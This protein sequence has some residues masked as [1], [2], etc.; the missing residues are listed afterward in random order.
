[1]RGA[2]TFGITLRGNSQEPRTFESEGECIAFVETL[3]AE[4]RYPA[5]CTMLEV[6]TEFYGKAGQEC[7]ALYWYILENKVYVSHVTEQEF[8]QD[9]KGIREIITANQ[10]TRRRQPEITAYIKKH[11]TDSEAQAWMESPMITHTLL[12]TVKKASRTMGFQ[13]AIRK[14]NR[15]LQNPRRGISSKP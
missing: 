1:M 15:V 10:K 14:V 3:P 11:W 2:P 7:E 12:I 13:E 8:R 6:G 9:W 4:D 5:L